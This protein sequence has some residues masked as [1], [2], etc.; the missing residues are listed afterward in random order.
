M[1]NFLNFIKPGVISGN[2]LNKIFYLIKKYNIALIAINCV[3]TNT[4]N[5][6]LESARIYK[7]IV[8]IQFSYSGSCFFINSNFNEFSKLKSSIFGSILAAKYIHEASLFY[9]VPVILHTD[10]CLKENLNWIDGLLEYNKDY[11]SSF[12]KSLFTSHMIDLSNYSLKKNLDIS[13][14]YLNKFSKF[15]ILLEIELGCTGGEE[16]GIDNS[17]ISTSKLYTNPKDILFTYNK[18]IKISNN[19]LIAASFGNTHGV[20]KPGNIVL[21][22]KILLNAQKLVKDF[23]SIKEINPLNFVFHGGS[24]TDYKIILESIKYGVVK[25]NLDTDIQWNYWFGILKYY[26]DNKYYLHSQLGNPNGNYN[27]NK[28]FYDPRV[29]INKGQINIIKY[30]SKIFDILKC[31]NILNI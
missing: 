19:F 16:D 7:T 12:G 24:G 27:P 21:C 4:I 9:K 14:Y 18:L 26:R 6:I 10:H 1:K 30:L 25:I 8:I 13:C 3:D 20:Y 2:N 31:K 17:N 23:N 15:N 22:P 29:W 5:S 28:K 11:Y